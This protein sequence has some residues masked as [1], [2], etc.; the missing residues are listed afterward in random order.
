MVKIAVITPPRLKVT[1]ALNEIA[2]KITVFNNFKRVEG[3]FVK[4]R[5]AKINIPN[6]KIVA[7]WLAPQPPELALLDVVPESTSLT[8]GL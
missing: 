2:Q 5:T 3:D 6:A 1:I 4:N 8:V 7:T